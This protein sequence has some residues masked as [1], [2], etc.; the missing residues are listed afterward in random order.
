MLRVINTEIVDVIPHFT[1]IVKFQR[2]IER[3]ININCGGLGAQFIFY[4][5]KEIG[6]FVDLYPFYVNFGKNYDY[7]IKRN[8]MFGLMFNF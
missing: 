1:Y 4:P 5:V 3:N 7:D 2:D 8:Y 6:L